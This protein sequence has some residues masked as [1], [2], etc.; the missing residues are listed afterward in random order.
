MKRDLELEATIVEKYVAVAPVLDERSR[1]RWAAAESKAIG[2]G[3]DA[4]VSSA[5]GL[6]RETIRKGRREIARGEAPTGRIRAPGAGR[7]GI[8]QDQPGI[9]AA[10]EALVDALTRGDPTSPL[11]WTCKSRAKLTAALTEQGWRVSSTTV[12]RLLHC[13][14]YRLQ[15][16]RKRREGV[17]H[18]DRNAQ[19]EHINQTADEYLT[20]GEP[21]MSVDTKKKELVGNFANRG[22]E[23]QPKGTPPG[24]S[25]ARLPDRRRGQ[26]DSVRCLRHG[27]QR[28]VGE[29]WARPRYA[30]LRGG[31]DTSLLAEDGPARLSEG[32]EAVHHGRCGREQRVPI[33]AWKHELQRF[34]DRTGLTIEV[35][36]FPPGT[37]KWNKIEHRLFCH[38]TANWRGTPLATWETIVDRIG[39]TRTAAGLRVRA[40]LD[41]R[42]Y[43]TGVTVTKSQMDAVAL[44]PDEFHGEWNYKL[45]VDK[46]ISITVLT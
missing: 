13:L 1:R 45:V 30:R 7:P 41:T 10:V 40:A 46:P 32:D 23:W 35:S 4:L 37:S 38:I 31:L 43:P 27:T 12:G 28:S 16:V 8:E 17:T 22:R 3:G 19:F 2:Y 11:R 21:V 42:E 5:T 44:V 14:G 18:P 9:M 39:N 20:S 36:H 33:H 6:A 26:G 29:R 34:A 24:C 15:S 25:R